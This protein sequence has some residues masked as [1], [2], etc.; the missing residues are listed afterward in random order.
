MDAWQIIAITKDRFSPRRAPR[1]AEL[2]PFESALVSSWK[3][4]GCRWFFSALLGALR[5]ESCFANRHKS[6]G[7]VRI[8][9]LAQ[10]L[11]PT[12]EKAC[13]GERA[14]VKMLGDLGER[15]VLK[16]LEDDG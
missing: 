14:A 3:N 9:E 12:L 13:D 16:V 7:S 15:P 11:Q 8:H 1:G 6:R 10:L 5:G 4:A 2:R